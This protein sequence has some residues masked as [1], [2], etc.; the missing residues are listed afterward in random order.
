MSPG[1]IERRKSRC[2]STPSTAAPCSA[3]RVVCVSIDS[4]AAIKSGSSAYIHH[5]TIRVLAKL[6]F[7]E[8]DSLAVG[9]S[10]VAQL[11]LGA[12]LL[13]FVGDRLIVRDASEQQTIA[14]GVVFNVDSTPNDF[15]STH[16]RALLAS[17]TAAPDDVEGGLLPV[18]ADAAVLA[19]E[20]EHGG[21]A[22]AQL[23]RAHAVAH[24]LQSSGL[25]QP[26]ERDVHVNR[27][28]FVD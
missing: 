20:E 16:Q 24:A 12:P 23:R 14:G 19:G 26:I 17:R 8:T 25:P 2:G 18:V 3:S 7:A 10:A 11:R 22:T 4:R 28:L 9:Q 27:P 1:I 6:I 15:R 5:G 21:L 13:A